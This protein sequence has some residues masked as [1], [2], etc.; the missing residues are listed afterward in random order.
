MSIEIDVKNFVDYKDKLQDLNAKLDDVFSEALYEI[1][2][3]MLRLAKKNTPTGVYPKG[4]G[5]TGGS[6]R[7]AWYITDITKTQDGYL[8][9]L[10]NDTAYASFVEYGHRTRDHKKWVDGKF[11]LTIAENKVKAKVDE[12]VKRHLQEAFEKL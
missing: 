5:K 4:S 9:E 2:G 1:A 8:I 6:L 12:I 7:R 10:K 3:R 11:M